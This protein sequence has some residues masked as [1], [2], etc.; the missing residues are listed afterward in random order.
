MTPTLIRYE[1]ADDF[2]RL[3]LRN[4]TNHELREVLIGLWC[5]LDADDRADHINSLNHYHTD[6]DAYLSPIARALKEGKEGDG[7][8][9]IRTLVDRVKP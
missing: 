2:L 3:T 9:D 1:R 8:I 7:T 4:V 6:P 5:R